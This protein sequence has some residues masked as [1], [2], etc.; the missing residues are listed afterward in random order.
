V[1]FSHIQNQKDLHPQNTLE[2]YDFFGFNAT[3]AGRAQVADKKPPGGMPEGFVCNGWILLGTA[4]SL[5]G[6]TYT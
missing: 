2:Q 6:Y 1:N 5:Y 3:F 4:E